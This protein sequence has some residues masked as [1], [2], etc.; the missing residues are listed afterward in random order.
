VRRGAPAAASASRERGVP[1]HKL[2]QW[3]AYSLID[4]GVIV[5]RASFD[6][7]AA[8]DVASELIVEWR[9]LTVALMDG[10]RASAPPLAQARRSCA[11]RPSF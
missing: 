11:G 5:P 8:H 9:A 10:L 6:P 7:V 1:F 3:L 2:S 4:T